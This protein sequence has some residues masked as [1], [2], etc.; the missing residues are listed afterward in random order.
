MYSFW[1]SVVRWNKKTSFG[2]YFPKSAYLDKSGKYPRS[3][4]LACSFKNL[5]GVEEN[6]KEIRCGKWFK[7]KWK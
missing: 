5:P 3:E 7:L 4:F 1:G 2:Q 6:Y